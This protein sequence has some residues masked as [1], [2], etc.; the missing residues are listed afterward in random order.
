M[1]YVVALRHF[2]ATG[3]AMIARSATRGTVV[4]LGDSA[5]AEMRLAGAGAAPVELLADSTGWRVRR[6]DGSGH[7]VRDGDSIALGPWL[8]VF[9]DFDGT[10][11]EPTHVDID[12]PR[13]EVP[14]CDPVVLRDPAPTILGAAPWCGLTASGIDVPAV[15][16]VAR[17]ARGATIVYPIPGVELRRNGRAVTAR[18]GLSDGDVLDTGR[19]SP[20][21]VRF[22]DPR[23]ELDRLL[24]AL[25]SGGTL[26]E[27]A[28]APPRCAFVTRTEAALWTATAMI[29]IAFGSVVWWRW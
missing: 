1:L 22:S 3:A 4:R 11:A 16:I 6:P 13:F 5:R 18:I 19:A 26:P 15:A 10:A 24:V 9:V 2:G 21:R 27:A 17:D 23:E 8:V 25:R 14:D 7:R 29:L 20:T 12:L 28:P